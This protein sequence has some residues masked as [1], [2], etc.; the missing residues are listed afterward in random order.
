MICWECVDEDYLRNQIQS[1][2]AKAECS[3]C[4]DSRRRCYS[5]EE[6]A[7]LVEAAFEQHFRR[8]AD[9]DYEGISRYTD[10]EREGEPVVDV[11]EQYTEIPTEAAQDIQT[12][13]EDKHSDYE[14]Y[15]MGEECPFAD[16]SYY[17]E[18]EIESQHWHAAW[19]ELERSLRTESRFF[20]ETAAEHL[21]NIFNNIDQLTPRGDEPLVIEAGPGMALNTLYRA[22]VFH[23]DD[24]LKKA[25]ARPEREL[26]PPPAKLAAAG[27]MNARGIS[28]FYGASSANVAIAEVRPPVGSQVA[29]AQFVILRP[30]RLLNLSALNRISSP[31][32]IF[33]P[34]WAEVL[35]R[36]SFIRSLCERMTR[37]VMPN[38]QD[39]EYLITQAVADYLATKS[40]PIFDGL[41]FPSVQTGNE[42]QNVVLFHKASRVK[43]LDDLNHAKVHVTTFTHG[44]DGP[45]RDYWVSISPNNLPPRSRRFSFFDPL[46]ETDMEQFA[47]NSE[48]LR[49]TTLEIDAQT[50]RVHIVQAVDYSWDDHRVM[51]HQN[52]MPEAAP[53]EDQDGTAYTDL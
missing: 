35:A 45:E 50:I 25:L 20:S 24:D 12:L 41:V 11:I 47:S 29:V 33:D 15:Q 53:A 31:G 39:W 28:V 36:V 19:N 1:L 8:T 37:P 40:T 30:L 34:D 44:E 38:D 43:T 4:L 5:I 27:R 9:N 17:E 10:W 48:D 49:E 13:L 52:P 18:R 3:Y 42:H 14:R 6:M 51:W 2:G 21:G 26:G 22:R 23:S 32:S 7:E 46:D 16:D